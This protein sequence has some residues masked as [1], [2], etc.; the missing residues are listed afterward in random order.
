MHYTAIGDTVNIASRVE[1]TT[2]KYDTHLLVTEEVVQACAG[3]D[4]LKHVD[5]EF[6]AETQVKGRIAPVR[7]YRCGEA[8]YA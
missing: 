4:E 2:R 6:V 1:S 7:L 8:A 3:A 5:W